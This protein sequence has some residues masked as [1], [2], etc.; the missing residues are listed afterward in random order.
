MTFIDKMLG[1]VAGVLLGLVTVSASAGEWVEGI[2][3]EK[4][5]NVI[6]YQGKFVEGEFA[7]LFYRS[8]GEKKYSG[9][10][11]N[12]YYWLRMALNF[13][14]RTI[15]GFDGVSL[16][17]KNSD[18]HFENQLVLVNGPARRLGVLTGSYDVGANGGW[19]PNRNYH[20]NFHT[21]FRSRA[22]LRE[23]SRS[24]PCD[25]GEGTWIYVELAGSLREEMRRVDDTAGLTLS[26][27]LDKAVKDAAEGNASGKREFY[28]PRP[29]IY[30]ANRL[31][32]GARFEEYTSINLTI[33][34]TFRRALWDEALWRQ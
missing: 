6:L 26:E 15:S 12:N 7:H 13:E 5:W 32:I 9:D 2:S 23:G 19:A 17:K 18:G 31:L 3:P 28:S 33:D 29:A 4:G 24:V 22:D 11:R 30:A 20:P 1:P 27:I 34:D 10:T 25:T 21:C 14:G 8:S 16:A